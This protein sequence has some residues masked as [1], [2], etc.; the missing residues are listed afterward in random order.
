[1]YYMYD[2]IINIYNYQ[3]GQFFTTWPK[4]MS[5]ISRSTDGEEKY[6]SQMRMPHKRENRNVLRRGLR[7]AGDV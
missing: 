5:I 4:I 2:S 7:A 3:R 1:M 6:I